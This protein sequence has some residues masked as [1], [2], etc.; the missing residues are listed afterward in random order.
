MNVRA[1][2]VIVGFGAEEFL[3]DCLDAAQGVAA[4]EDEILLVDNGIDHADKRRVDWPDRIRVLR[5]GT[6]LGFAGGVNHAVAESFGEFV[7]LLNSDAIVRAGAI[8]ALLSAS[9]ATPATIATGCLRLAEAPDLVNSAGNP[10]HFTGVCWA[11]G[12]GEPASS[13]AERRHVATAS[14]GFM[15]I[16]RT[17]WD[18]LQGFNEAYFAYHED[19]ELSARV[20]LMGGQ[21]VFVPDAVALHHYDFSRNARKMY[22]LERNRLITVLTVYPSGLRRRVLPALALSELGLLAVAAREGWLA[23]K[24]DAYRWLWEHRR[25]LRRRRAAVQHTWVRDPDALT[26]LLA[27]RIEPAMIDHPPLLKVANAGMSAYWRLMRPRTS[28][29]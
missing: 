23:N 3:E 6:N 19:A 17:A 7:V 13:H 16:R 2:I 28:A 18:D 8:D 9:D 12:Y 24:T 11:G 4:S 10:M 27:S 20:W 29:R 25:D 14:G 22:L 26:P 21:V 15:A 1:S 5:P